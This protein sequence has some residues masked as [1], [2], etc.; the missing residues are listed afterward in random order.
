MLQ[1]LENKQ[2][3]ITMRGYKIGNL[4]TLKVMQK[5]KH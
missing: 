4:N 2:C 3:K 1:I 5:I